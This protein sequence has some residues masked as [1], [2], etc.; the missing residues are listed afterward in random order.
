MSDLTSSDAYFDRVG[1]MYRGTLA[2][3]LLQRSV[4]D[5]DGCWIWQLTANRAGY[6]K[7]KYR[8]LGIMYAHRAAYL[9]FIGPI[10]EGMTVDH[11]CYVTLCVNPEHLRLLT[12]SDNARGQR[13][14]HNPTCQRGHAWTPENTVRR[15][16]R[17]TGPLTRRC[18]TC[19]TMQ[20]EAR[21]LR[22]LAS[23]TPDV[24]AAA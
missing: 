11:L 24:A 17:P 20:Q 7:L 3:R 15:K 1:R 12:R 22:L 16:S 10:P 9:A 18:R 23:R 8:A 6:G 14:V 19:Q 4:V 13:K 2:E 21:K 5:A